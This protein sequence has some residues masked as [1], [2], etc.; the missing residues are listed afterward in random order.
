MNPRI[1]VVA[2]THTETERAQLLDLGARQ[3]MLGKREL[4]I[5]LARYTLRR[6]RV[7]APETEAIAQGL[8]GRG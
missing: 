7:S 3:A 6:F 1:E 2:R 8:R 5:Q 4:A